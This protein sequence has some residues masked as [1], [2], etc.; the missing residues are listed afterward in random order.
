[1]GR[2]LS[3]GGKF[4]FVGNDTTISGQDTRFDKELAVGYRIQF[5]SGNSRSQVYQVKKIV[6]ATNFVI[7]G[8]LTEADKL[9]L[10]QAEDVQIEVVETVRQGSSFRVTVYPEDIEAPIRQVAFFV[11]G[12]PAF[13][14]PINL[15][16]FA[17][18]FN[19]STVGVHEINAIATDS[20]GAQTVITKTFY[21]EE[22]IGLLPQGNLQVG[23]QRWPPAAL[24]RGRIAGIQALLATGAGTPN[25]NPAPLGGVIG[26]VFPDFSFVPLQ[27][28]IRVSQGS[29]LLANVSF[30]DVDGA[31]NTVD[32]VE[33]Y[34]NGELL[35]IQHDDPFFFTFTPTGRRTSLLTG[36]DLNGNGILDPGEDPM[37][38][39]FTAV[40]ID[41]DGNRNSQTINGLIDGPFPSYR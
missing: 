29:S 36:R 4:T 41:I 1:M 34:L 19:A 20:R 37:N 11:D 15:F 27:G 2:V 8:G 5:Q 26:P 31:G 23:L 7:T 12:A 17:L 16:P 18:D 3:G 28:M 32:R 38:W 35:G 24:N 6:D 14:S 21:V 33:Y 9:L 22:S 39:E 30:I 40:G 10:Q 13:N 25:Q